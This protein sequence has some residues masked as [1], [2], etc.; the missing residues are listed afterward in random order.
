MSIKA[1]S[2]SINIECNTPT[3]KLV[4][5]ILSNYADENNSC[6]PSEKH[7]A[8]ICNISDRSIRRCLKWLEENK[9][10]RIEHIEGYSN[11]YFL[12]VD[13]SVQTVRTQTT[14]NTKEDTKVLNKEISLMFE[15][16]WKK[17][18]RKVG[19][20]LARKSFLKIADDKNFPILMKSLERFTHEHLDTEEKY[21]PHASTWLNQKRYLDYLEK[22]KNVSL[23]KIAG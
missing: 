9:L 13:T 15:V 18:P 1:L 10:L 5:I 22:D 2:W 11:R 19:K 14:N 17:Y 3:T 7:L 4:L 8:K 21:I 16:F 6:Y 12:S 23:N 20:H